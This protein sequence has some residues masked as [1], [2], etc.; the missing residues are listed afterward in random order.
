MKTYKQL[1]EDIEVV[2]SA[3]VPKATKKGWKDITSHFHRTDKTDLGEIHPGYRMHRE[4]HDHGT[5][6]YIHHVGSNQIVGH[7][8]TGMDGKNIH[9]A[10]VDVHPHHTSK[11]IGASLPVEAYRHLHR[12]GY[13]VHADNKQSVGGAKIWHRMMK[14][15]ELSKHVEAREMSKSR[16]NADKIDTK[17]I[18]GTHSPAV[19]R[20]MEM[21]HG[22][23]V[24]DSRFPNKVNAKHGIYTSLVLKGKKK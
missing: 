22:I 6:F 20:K 19:R 1:L 3:D 11:H 4:N 10:G 7:V 13:N 16:H 17:R 12:R 2:S 18:W 15:P 23:Q 14:D 24:D 8:S 5:S 21:R 9:V